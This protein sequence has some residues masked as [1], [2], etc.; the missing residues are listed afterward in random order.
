MP[1]VGTNGIRLY[2]ETQGTGEPLVLIAGLGY[3]LWQWHKVMPGLAQHFQVVAFDNRGAGQS[4]KPEGPYNAKMLADDTAGLIEALGISPAMVMGHSMGGFI[5]QELALSYPQHVETL[6]L[7]STNFGGPN[8]IPITSEAMA[9]LT[10]TSLPPQERVRQ[11]VLV[12]CA[13]GF[14]EQHP[15][16]VEELIAYRMSIPVPPAAYQSQMAIGMGLLTY[17][18]SFEPRLSG[19]SM[20]T[21]VMSG[22]EDKTVP[23]GNVDLLAKAIPNACTY[24]LEGTSHLFMIEAPERTVDALVSLLK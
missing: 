18:A 22:G 4:G 8:H 21:I 6:V 3:G 1:F 2:Y 9:I 13:E 16:V 10:T 7:A 23:P 14:A 20:P 11:G 15:E 12:A 5:A 19:I 17:E 24:I